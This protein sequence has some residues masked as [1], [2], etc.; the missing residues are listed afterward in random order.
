MQNVEIMT[1]KQLYRGI[2]RGMIRYPSTNRAL[3]RQAIVEDVADWKKL[4]D[5]MEVKKAHKKMRMLYGHVHMWGAKMDEI[6]DPTS[7]AIDEP[8]PARDINQK[9]DEDF[10]YF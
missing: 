5:D 1:V 6:N 3:M 2:L 8:L 10:V 4:T 7:G 9:R